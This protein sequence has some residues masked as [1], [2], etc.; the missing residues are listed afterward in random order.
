MKIELNYDILA[1]LCQNL[2]ETDINSLCCVNKYFESSLKPIR[3]V[4]LSSC[5]LRS[6]LDGLFEPL[7]VR[8]LKIGCRLDNISGY[9]TLFKFVTCDSL[10][11]DPS[12][13]GIDFLFPLRFASGIKHLAILKGSFS[14]VNLSPFHSLRSVT[15]ENQ[16]DGYSMNQHLKKHSNIVK[17]TIRNCDFEAKSE[18]Q[19]YIFGG[20]NSLPLVEYT[21][22]IP[23]IKELLAF[24]CSIKSNGIAFEL[25]SL[26]PLWFPEL[27]TFVCHTAEISDLKPLLLR[28]KNLEYLELKSAF[29]K[30]NDL[31]CSSCLKQLNLIADTI[32]LDA[33]IADLKL[34]SLKLTCRSMI[35][36]AY[37]PHMPA[38]DSILIETKNGKIHK[39]GGL[40]YFFKEKWLRIE[41]AD[42]LRV[43]NKN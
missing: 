23:E 11:I 19:D 42:A 9:D 14:S 22:K 8:E 32:S 15:I 43:M 26:T 12:N 34:K 18:L 2:S 21:R 7:H 30:L 20:Q 29:L 10:I 31:E 40:W 35:S 6:F 41:E 1:V 4:N 16:K 28:C 38:C 33:A 27:T 24:N 37:I 39:N 17:L 36:S 13:L 3:R 25:F 5:N